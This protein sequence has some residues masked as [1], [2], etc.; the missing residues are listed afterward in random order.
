MMVITVAKLVENLICA[1][2]ALGI[3]HVLSHSPFLQM[4][5]PK[6]REVK[7]LTQGRTASKLLSRD[8]NLGFQSLSSFFFSNV[9][10]I[11]LC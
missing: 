9:F 4:G 11:I 5:K 8:S 2:A 10:F 3:L 6:R 7:D 1:S